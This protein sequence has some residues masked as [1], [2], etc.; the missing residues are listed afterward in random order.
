MPYCKDT[1]ITGQGIVQW[2]ST[3]RPVPTQDGALW[4]EPSA[5]NMAS[6]HRWGIRARGAKNT[7]MSLARGT[8]AVIAS[9]ARGA[10]YYRIDAMMRPQEKYHK[11]EEVFTR[12]GIKHMA[13]E[14][15]EF[16]DLTALV[17]KGVV[18][19]DPQNVDGENCM[20]GGVK[21]TAT[22]KMD[23]NDYHSNEQG[24]FMIV[25]TPVSRLL[26]GRKVPPEVDN[27]TYRLTPAR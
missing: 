16:L 15:E 18:Q 25:L 26:R 27:L 9:F 22:T 10:F 12:V 8:P 13:A 19:F 17:I 21:I 14:E 2:R 7:L 1:H 6:D 3:W 11:Y 24:I 4:F 20:A 5:H 23:T